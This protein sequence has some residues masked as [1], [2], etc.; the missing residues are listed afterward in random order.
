MGSATSVI[1]D[2]R[3]RRLLVHAN[4]YPRTGEVRTLRWRLSGKSCGVKK[5]VRQKDL[6]R[7]Q[8]DLSWFEKRSSFHFAGH[9]GF[10]PNFR[11]P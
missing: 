8:L 2:G 5:R 1:R 4:R 7:R 10:A 6:Q 9:P 11:D 3:G